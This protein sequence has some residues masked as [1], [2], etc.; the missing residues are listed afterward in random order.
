[1]KRILT[2]EAYLG[3]MV[4]GKTEKVNYKVKRHAM[5]PKGEWVRVEGTH[6]AI[7]SADDFAVAQN[8]LKADGRRSP[9]TG[10]VS[11]FMGLLFCGDCGQQMVR[12][13]VRYQGRAKVYYICSTKNRGGGRDAAGTA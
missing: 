9:A 10:A 2:N 5:K 7:V 6:E 3:H 12:R 4:Q 11:P 1:M 13:V 8:L